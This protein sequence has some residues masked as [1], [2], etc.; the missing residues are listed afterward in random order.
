MLKDPVVSFS[1]KRNKNRHSPLTNYI[2]AVF[3]F[4]PRGRPTGFLHRFK[5]AIYAIDSTTIQLALNC[6][7]WAKHR[8]RRG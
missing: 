7:D 1:G 5:K 4:N 3:R 6:I 8:R 2:L